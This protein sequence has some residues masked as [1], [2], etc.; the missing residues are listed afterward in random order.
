MA[1]EHDLAVRSHRLADVELGGGDGLALQ[2]LRLQRLARVQDARAR[3][4]DRAALPHDVDVPVHP[5]ARLRE[6]VVEVE[7]VRVGIAEEVDDLAVLV[8]ALGQPGLLG[9]HRGRGQYGGDGGP[10]PQRSLRPLIT[11]AAGPGNVFTKLTAMRPSGSL[12]T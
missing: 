2:D 11:T 1:D 12:T 6:V 7:G 3:I 9:A 5:F 8:R 4:G 10:G